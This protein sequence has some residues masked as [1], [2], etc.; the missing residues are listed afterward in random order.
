MKSLSIIL[1]LYIVAFSFVSL[2]NHELYQTFGWDLG[3]FDQLLWQVGDRG[4]WNFV[5]TIGDINLVGDHFQPI[6]YLLAPLYWLW[7][8]IR[9]ILI[10]QTIL[11]ASA[12]IPLYL[13]ARSKTKNTLLS[14][15]ISCL[16]LLFHG[17]QFTLTNEFHQSAFIP[18]FLSLGFYFLE[19]GRTKQGIVSILALLFVRE[20]A[21]LLIA[22]IGMMYLVRRR[23]KLGTSLTIVGVTSFFLLVSLVIPKVSSQDRYIHYGYGELGSTPTEVLNSSLENPVRTIQLLISPN[24]KLIQVRNSLLAFGGMPLL[25]PTS[26][27]PVLIH[28]AVRFI[29]TRNVHRWLD[30]NHYAA[31][32]GPLLAFA[33]IQ[34]MGHVRQ[35]T[36]T[37][38]TMLIIGILGTSLLVHAPI[39]A[40]TK[41][42]L[43]F[44]PQW[45]KDANQL[46]AAVPIEAAIA[47]NNSL[48][49]HLTHRD[50]IYLLPDI[51]D[52]EYIA[53][54]LSDGPN[55]YAPWG[56]ERM[57]EYVD[58]LMDN[59]EWEVEEQIGQAFL[60][61][62]Q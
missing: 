47:A 34:A 9:V 35:A 44:T 45:V 40:L 28:Y 55:K 50:K 1:V 22:G 27:I 12:A 51:R 62:R 11:V 49:P 23:T 32:L 16:Y 38:L 25:S 13:L 8:D 48:I 52:A 37:V 60:L 58:E 6:L 42:Q 21:A 14:I 36:S 2:R 61:K 57:R 31:P 24:E 7:D 53:V 10:A 18:L 46:I 20:E 17:T 19:T 43:Y 26:L 30:T 59:G 4:N 3:F 5:S 56:Y 54:D 15:S 41:S 29:D 33:T 39:F